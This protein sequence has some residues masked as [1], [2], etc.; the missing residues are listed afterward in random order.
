M[1][2]D[3]QCW[4]ALHPS[5][6]RFAHRPIRIATVGA[7]LECFADTTYGFSVDEFEVVEFFSARFLGHFSNPPGYAA[8]KR[9]GYIDNTTRSLPGQELFRIY[10]RPPQGLD[11]TDSQRYL[12]VVSCSLAIGMNDRRSGMTIGR[13]QEG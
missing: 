6:L 4:T 3:V 1:P 5:A 11:K 7:A 8:A 10:F 13:S 12:A 2:Q 9:F